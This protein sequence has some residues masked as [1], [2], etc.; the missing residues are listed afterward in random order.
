MNS[1]AS[2]AAETLRE[3]DYSKQGILNRESGLMNE[4]KKNDGSNTLFGVPKSPPPPPRWHIFAARFAPSASL[5]DLIEYCSNQGAKP[6]TVRMLSKPESKV[7][8]FHC[9]FE[10]TMKEKIQSADFWPENVS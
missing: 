2:Q 5:E 6:V 9:L 10:N 3:D 4:T 8:S 7:K 1:S